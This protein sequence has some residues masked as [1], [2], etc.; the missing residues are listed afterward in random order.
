MESQKQPFLYYSHYT[1]SHQSSRFPSPTFDPKAVTRASW[2][3]KQV[4]PKKAGPL[5]SFGRHPDAYPLTTR[6][7]TQYIPL[8]PHLK[9]WIRALRFSQLVLRVLELNVALGLL[10]CAILLVGIESTTAWIL[11]ITPGASIIHTI[12]AIHHLSR[13]AA[14]RPPASSAAYQAFASAIDL[15]ACGLYIFGAVSAHA[16]GSQWGIRLQNT[17]LLGYIVSTETWA[18]VSAAA[19]QGISFAVSLW[20]AYQFRKISQMPPDMNPLEDHLTARPKHKRNKSSVATCQSDDSTINIPITE[21]R[22]SVSFFDTRMRPFSS[23]SSWTRVPTTAG[24]SHYSPV[25]EEP[26]YEDAYNLATKD[27]PKSYPLP[28]KTASSAQRLHQQSSKMSLSTPRSQR[29][30]RGYRANDLPDFASDS[31]SD[32]N[33]NLNAGSDLESEPEDSKYAGISVSR[34]RP[35]HHPN[36]LSSNPL[37]EASWM[38]GNGMTVEHSPPRHPNNAPK[39]LALRDSSIQLDAHFSSKPLGNNRVVSSGNDFD[40]YRLQPQARHVSGK[41]VEEGQAGALGKF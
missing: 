18:L 41:M 26:S 31:D 32:V 11:R 20:L 1:P 6:T 37:S 14:A 28:L 24:S 30:I 3:P 12:Y 38:K 19:L 2:E 33:P 4:K 34:R 39:K 9:Q 5:I 40:S 8:G 13:H 16:T 29:P 35:Q 36:P 7:S 23:S 15:A 17:E 22:S 21:P 10:V 25:S 27:I